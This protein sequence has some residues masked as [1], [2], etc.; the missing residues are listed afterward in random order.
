MLPFAVIRDLQAVPM[1]LIPAFTALVAAPVDCQVERVTVGRAGATVAARASQR[2]ATVRRP[3]GVT[4]R[5]GGSAAGG[6][7]GTVFE[8]RDSGNKPTPLVCLDEYTYLVGGVRCLLAI[9]LA[10]AADRFETLT[11]V[12]GYCGLRFGEAVALRRWHGG[13]G[14]DGAFVR[15]RGNR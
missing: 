10:K 13:S 1:V 7:W 5:V 9:V 4:L 6:H 2:C 14:A 12:L 3:S 11:L 15:N 8:G